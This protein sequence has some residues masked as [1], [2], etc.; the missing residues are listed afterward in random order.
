V[1]LIVGATG[2]LLMA[3]ADSLPAAAVA[4][5]LIGG[6]SGGEIDVNPYLLAR[7]FGLRSLATLYGFN[8][9]ALGIASAIGPILMGRAFD[10]TGTYTLIVTQLAIVTLLVAGLLLTLPS[11]VKVQE[12]AANLRPEPSS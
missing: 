6:G 1:Q 12:E 3:T 4:A 8:W 2:G 7:Y 11:E 9:M 5:A 10:A